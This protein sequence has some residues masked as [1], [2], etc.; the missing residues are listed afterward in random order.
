MGRNCRLVRLD[1]LAGDDAFALFTEKVGHETLNSDHR[2]RKIAEEIINDYCQ[3]LPLALTATGTALS[4]KKT[5]EEWVVA[6]RNLKKSSANFPGMGKSFFPL[7]KLSYDNLDDGAKRCFLS[8]AL[9]PENYSICN[10]E[11]IECWMGLGF[12]NELDISVAYSH[13]C[14]VIN[15]LKGASLLTPG[16]IET[17][18]RMHQTIRGLALWIASD[19][20]ENREKWIVTLDSSLKAGTHHFNWSNAERV[21]FMYNDIEEFPLQTKCEDLT[22]LILKGNMSLTSVPPGFFARMPALTY[23]DLSNT[24]IEEL[25]ADIRRLTKLKYLNL[26]HTRL[27]SLPMEVEHLKELEYLLLYRTLNMK[28]IPRKVL[29]GLSKLRVLDLSASGNGYDL[30]IR[31]GGTGSSQG[32]RAGADILD[33]ECFGRDKNRKSSLALGIMV[34]SVKALCRLSKLSGLCTRR[35]CMNNLEGFQGTLDLLSPNLLGSTNGKIGKSLR[36]LTI[37]NCDRLVKLLMVGA[38]RELAEMKTAAAHGPRLLGLE[39]LQLLELRRMKEISWKGVTAEDL[40]PSLRELTIYKCDELKNVSWVLKLPSL[41]Y[42]QLQECAEMEVVIGD[43]ADVIKIPEQAFPKLKGIILDELPSLSK[44]CNRSLCFPA[45]EFLQVSG[46]L[47]LVKLPF[48]PEIRNGNL[49]KIQGEKMWWECL[50]WDDKSIKRELLDCCFFIPPRAPLTTLPTRRSEPVE[51][52][53]SLGSFYRAVL[54]PI[55]LPFMLLSLSTVLPPS[56]LLICMFL[57]FVGRWGLLQR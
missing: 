44:I 21:S 37:M 22:T 42:L 6:N 55:S 11:L 16:D 46:C 27:T 18:V 41:E 7:L 48:R 39:I 15:I 45:L 56:I 35:L 31:N 29:L 24:G 30:D 14:H 43:E 8:C 33:L 57:L 36:E 47:K 13:G 5:Y 49:K 19:Y 52:N 32:G 23:L 51:K 50:Q 3:R 4:S 28:P 17:E 40:L 53:S 9:W 20:G 2:I 10:D 54:L 25:P 26:S 38:A 34:V 12:I 1:C